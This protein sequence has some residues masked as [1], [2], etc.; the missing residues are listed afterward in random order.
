MMMM[1]TIMMMM[2]MQHEEGEGEGGCC[3]CCLICCKVWPGAS[4]GRKFNGKKNIVCQ[5][6]VVAFAV[7]VAVQNNAQNFV[8]LNQHTDGKV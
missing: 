7:V 5:V 2:M 6:I 3:S 4:T 8:Q 1:T